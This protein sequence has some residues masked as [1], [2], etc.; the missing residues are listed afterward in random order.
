MRQSSALH[1]QTH[2]DSYWTTT[3]R[4]GG[5][6]GTGGLVRVDG[7]RGTVENLAGAGAVAGD[8]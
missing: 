1:A 6:T 2:P 4:Q 8:R 7:A 5:A 3:G